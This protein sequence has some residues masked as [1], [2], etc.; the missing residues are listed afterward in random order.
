MNLGDTFRPDRML[1]AWMSPSLNTV[2][3]ALVLVQAVVLVIWGTLAGFSFDWSSAVIP[4]SAMVGLGGLSLFYTVVRPDERIAVGTR[5][6]V[7]LMAVTAVGGPL[8]YLVATLDRP[9]L[10]G[11]FEALD[12]AI[13]FDWPAY[14]RLITGAPW[15]HAAVRFAYETFMPAFAV[16]VI[17]LAGTRQERQLSTF[18]AAFAVTTLVTIII[19]GLLPGLNPYVSGGYT[20]T[21]HPGI[22]ISATTEHVDVIMNLRS[23]QLRQLSLDGQVGI[24][25]FPSLHAACGMLF[26]LGLWSVPYVRWIGLVFGLAVF[27]ATPVDGS[28]YIVDVLSGIAI[29]WVSFALCARMRSLPTPMPATA[30]AV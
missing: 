24:I 19:S 10:D 22:R 8:S 2:I 26:V 3:L 13:G 23:G 17:C 18:V 6:M 28:H 5:A 16:T 15:L 1:A 27:V 14:F 30:L 21:S 9:L 4:V 29:A 20:V 7:Q 11:Q 12:R 25:T